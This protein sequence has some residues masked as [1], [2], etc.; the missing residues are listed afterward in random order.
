MHA[1]FI[2]SKKLNNFPAYFFINTHNENTHVRK[3]NMRMLAVYAYLLQFFDC[4]L[5]FVTRFVGLIRGHQ[6]VDH[7]RLQ[8][9]LLLVVC[10][11]RH[12]GD[13][14]AFNKFSFPILNLK[15]LEYLF[16]Y[17]RISSSAVKCS[18]L[19]DKSSYIFPK[20]KNNMNFP[21]KSLSNKFIFPV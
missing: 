4:L 21:Q 15:N 13:F 18:M 5:L 9:G 6:R 1:T 2:F 20:M 12:H 7:A 10:L 14:S 11:V 19:P 8:S 17:T 3:A 16:V